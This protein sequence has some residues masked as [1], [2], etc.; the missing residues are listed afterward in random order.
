MIE[1]LNYDEVPKNFVHCYQANCTLSERCLR[2]QAAHHVPSNKRKVLAINPSHSLKVDGQ[3]CPEFLTDKSIQYAYGMSQVFEGLPY[4]KAKAIKNEIIEL[5]GKTQFYRMKRKE[6]RISPKQ[7]E[8][9]EEVFLK[10]GITV[11]P[12]FDCYIE[13][14]LWS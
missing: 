7:Q 5:I 2:Y 10:H 4:Q 8:C 13:G 11:K 9:F 1:C 3:Q 14:H 6:I 12:K